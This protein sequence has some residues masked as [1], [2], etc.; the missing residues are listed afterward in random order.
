MA[1]ADFAEM[2]HESKAKRFGRETTGRGSAS[3]ILRRYWPNV[4]VSLTDEAIRYLESQSATVVDP[5]AD[6][7]R[8]SGSFTRVEVGLQKL[9]DGRSVLVETLRLSS[10]IVSFTSEQSQT[11]SRATV[12]LHIQTDPT[13]MNAATNTQGVVSVRRTDRREDGRYDL[14]EDQI[15]SFPIT[16]AGVLTA[17]ACGYTEV[18]TVSDNQRTCSNVGAAA[19]GTEVVKTFQILKDGTYAEVEKSRVARKLDF[20]GITNADGDKITTGKACAWSETMQ[21]SRGVTSVTIPTEELQ[22]I[23]RLGVDLQSDGSLIVRTEDRTSKDQ[24]SNGEVQ[25]CGYTVASVIHTASE[26]PA[27]VAANSV[28]VGTTVTVVNERNE[29]GTLRTRHDTRT[30]VN[31]TSNS[32]VNSCGYAVTVAHQTA[33]LEPVDNAGQAQGT[34]INA[35]NDRNEDGTLRTSKE[36]RVAA[37]QQSN[38]YVNAAGYTVATEIHTASNTEA[39]NVGQDTGIVIIAK[40]DRN[41]D[42]TL[43]TAKDTRTAVDQTSYSNAQAAGYTVTVE[44][45]TASNSEATVGTVAAGHIIRVV[46]RRNDDG[47]VASSKED[48]LA[49]LQSSQSYV[50]ACAYS[51]VTDRTVANT[52]ADTGVGGAGTGVTV[53]IDNEVRPDGWYDISKTVQSKTEINTGLIKYASVGGGVTNAVREIGAYLSVPFANV[54]NTINAY[55][56]AATPGWAVYPD[57]KVDGD[58]TASIYLES[59]AG[60]GASFVLGGESSHSY[61][62][63]TPDYGTVTVYVKFTTTR[64]TAYNHV[65]RAASG[66]VIAGAGAALTGVFGAEDGQYIKAVR[67]EAET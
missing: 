22:H 33:A 56:A 11:E 12:Q 7:E 26:T 29:D 41:D 16:K 51:V 46:N 45:H 53:R 64:E 24:T 49:V 39:T 44:N 25:A 8:A 17:N 54:G 30:A 28:N 48:R 60:G 35:R 65:A 14:V 47:T 40:N 23:K 31:Q 6:A 1:T 34:I 61:S 5:M 9:K 59:R 10:D 43:R 38:G 15:T 57:M 62:M 19:R 42:G 37:D 50:Q 13:V 20:T 32:Y 63:D 2:L 55:A 66:T 18:T 27:Q 36:T 21:V 52:G 3:R 58:G 4:P 67:V